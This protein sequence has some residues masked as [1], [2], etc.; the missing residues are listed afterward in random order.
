MCYDPKY[1]LRV[2]KEADRK[3][4]CV[5]L[6]A[7]LNLHEEAVEL[8]LQLDVELAKKRADS[9]GAA[10]PELRK[11]LWLRIARHVVEE[12]HDVERAMRFLQEAGGVLKIEDILPFFPEF[13][14]IDHFKDAIC[15]SLEEYNSHISVLQQQ[16]KEATESAQDIRKQMQQF[17]HRFGTVRPQEMCAICGFPLLSQTFVLFPCAHTFHTACLH[18]AMLPRLDK[19]QRMRFEQLSQADMTPGKTNQIRVRNKRSV[20]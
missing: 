19:S 9:A 13:V 1:A 11:K 6:Y 3:H 10:E 15:T 4:A 8:A 17:R 12:E 2:C 7:L 16:M 14:T 18:E 20:L 5:H